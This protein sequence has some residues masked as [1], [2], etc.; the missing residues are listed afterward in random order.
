MNIN[1]IYL[2]VVDILSIRDYFL[3]QLETLPIN[4]RKDE[5][6]MAKSKVTRPAAATSASNVLNN[7]STGAKSKSAAASALSQAKAPNKT[8]SPAVATKASSVMRDGRTNAESKSAA[9]SALAQA[10]SK[11]K[12]R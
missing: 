4:N 10:A 11:K 5:D 9:A 8:T 3:A 1:I 6:K 2:P 7:A 12:G